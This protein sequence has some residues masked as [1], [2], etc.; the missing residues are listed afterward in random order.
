MRLAA[1]AVMR[2]ASGPLR[3]TVHVPG[4]KAISHRMAL[5]AAVA[6]G[7]SVLRGFSRASDCAATVTIV[8]ALG[9]RMEET[10]G[11]LV[12]E[13]A[14]WDALRP[15]AEPLDCGRSGTTLRLACGL[16]AGSP[17]EVTLTGDPQLRRRPVD[18]IAE[19]LSRMGAGIETTMGR[20]PIRVRGGPLT[21]IEYALPVASAQVKS[22]VLLAGLR[23]E[24]TTAVV[25]SARTRDH[26]ER[27][28]AWLGVPIA[29]DDAPIRRITIRRAR[30]PR[31]QAAVPGDAS[32]AAAVLAAAAIVPR[33]AVTVQ[34]VGLNPT[35]T[36]FLD[37]LARMGARVDIEPAGDPQ[38][39]PA[40][41]VSVRHGGLSG[42][43]IAPADVPRLIDELPLIGV[44]GAVAEGVT[45]VRGAE[46]LRVKES[47]RIAGLVAG[48]RALGA[49]ADELPDGFVVSGPS[50]LHGG[51]VDALGDHR[52]AMAFA[53][54]ALAATDQ[55]R[56]DGFDSVADS[57]PTFPET[58]EAL[59]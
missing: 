20:P 11:D 54:A 55:A 17:L 32:S 56:I 39:E 13:G 27:L 51:A 8:R 10:R 15:P 4:D 16:L 3:G 12:I 5:A 18:R 22:A 6:R 33:S 1:P 53:V 26:T 48:L 57:F 35:R 46:E 9:V 28:L 37:V 44:L 59:R 45:V 34:D 49:D 29:V 40:G 14:G 24:G 52:L 38:P 23:A 19:P 30:L 58:L 47:D 25:E 36:A 50:S 2:P 7:R 43:E 41:T 42:V 21:G 31:F